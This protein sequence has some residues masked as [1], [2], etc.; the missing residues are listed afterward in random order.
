MARRGYVAFAACVAVMTTCFSGVPVWSRLPEDPAM[1][2]VREQAQKSQFVFRG[3]VVDVQPELNSQPYSSHFIAK[4]QIDRLYRGNLTGGAAIRFSLDHGL[5]MGHDC[6]N[7][8]PGELWLFFAVKGNGVLELFD[9]CSGALA[10]SPRLGPKSKLPGWPAQMES[11][12]LAGLEDPDLQSR[13]YSIQ[14]LGGLQ[15]P[16]SRP[17]LHEVIGKRKGIEAD[18]AIYATLRTG[19]FTVL[20]MV[21]TALASGDASLRAAID[22]ELQK[23]SDPAAVPGLLDIAKSAPN[24]HSRIEAMVSLVYYLKDPRAVPTLGANLSSSDDATRY[25]ALEGLDII[26]K[27]LACKRPPNPDENH[28][29]EVERAIASC[30]DWWERE[31]RHQMWVRE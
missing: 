1:V 7:F 19:D 8:R 9:D 23:V 26:T 22:Y 14:R 24:E 11:D 4:I 15:L 21:N 5:S 13:I 10:I 12:F 30:K 18:W 29:D 25:M 16:S 2:D 20:P 28:K 6:F 3:H 27:S 17:A 31:G